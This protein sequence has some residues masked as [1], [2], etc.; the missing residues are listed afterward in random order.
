MVRGENRIE[1]ALQALQ[2]IALYQFSIKH[3]NNDGGYESKAGIN[4]GNYYYTA[5][6]E[7]VLCKFL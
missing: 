5:I 4:V 1:A 3:R 2:Y 7:Y 6:I